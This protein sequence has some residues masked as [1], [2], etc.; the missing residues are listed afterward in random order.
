MSEHFDLQRGYRKW[1][2]LVQN[3]YLWCYGILTK[4]KQNANI[5]VFVV[6]DKEHKKTQYAD[7]TILVVWTH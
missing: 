1:Y 5:I 7:D 4:M 6:N 2:P 3:T